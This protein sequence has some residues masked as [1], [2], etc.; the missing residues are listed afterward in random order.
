MDIRRKAKVNSFIIV[1]CLLVVL[2][3]CL[4]VSTLAWLEETYIYYEDRNNIGAI[5]VVLLANGNK[6][7]G[8]TDENG[9]WTCNTPYEIPSGNTIRSL[10]LKC[11]NEG[12]IDALVRVTISIYYMENNNKRTALLVSGNPTTSGTISL[13]TNNWI[14][15]FPSETVACGYMYY[16]NVLSSYNT[17]TYGTDNIVTGTDIN[18]ETSIINQILVNSEQKDIVFYVDVSVDAVAYSGN[19][20]KKI[21]NNETTPEDIPVNAFPFGNKADLPSTWTA[22]R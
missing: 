22:W 1:L 3:S 5:N 19:I 18:G 20:Y 16:N 11:R 15:Q 4:I 21:E 14:R 12:N 2:C 13:D 7:E 6:I 10:N 9:V 8:S 17:R